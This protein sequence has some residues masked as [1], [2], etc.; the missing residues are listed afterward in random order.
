MCVF[1]TPILY[2]SSLPEIQIN[3]VNKTDRQTDVQ[4]EW[5][6]Y[7]SDGRELHQTKLT[8]P[9]DNY[10]AHIQYSTHTARLTYSSHSIMSILIN[11]KCAITIGTTS[12]HKEHQLSSM[13]PGHLRI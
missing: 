8:S 3:K 4:R 11:S 7:Q 2:N 9:V 13:D 1:S 5:T 10:T 12:I 6:T